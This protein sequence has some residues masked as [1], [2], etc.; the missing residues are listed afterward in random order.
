MA[1]AVA[2]R[3]PVVVKNLSPKALK[4]AKAFRGMTAAPTPAKLKGKHE[5]QIARAVRG[6]Y[7]G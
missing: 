5:R 1:K 6:Y 2:P 4:A 3:K 7:F